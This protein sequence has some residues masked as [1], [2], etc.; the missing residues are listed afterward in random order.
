MVT[1]SFPSY[2]TSS[3]PFI[4]KWH[5]REGRV[6]D[7][8]RLPH[9]DHH[10]PSLL[11]HHSNKNSIDS[12]PLDDNNNNIHHP[13]VGVKMEG[14]AKRRDGEDLLLDNGDMVDTSN[15]QLDRGRIASSH[16]KS[17]PRRYPINRLNSGISFLSD[18]GNPSTDS[19]PEKKSRVGIIVG[20]GL[21]AGLVAALGAAGYLY[22]SK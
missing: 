2:S 1:F 18:E 17:S 11:E 4:H 10:F 13:L 7:N 15:S 6:Q 21:A 16:F 3:D 9:Q 22:W 19:S 14:I 20:S 8:V 5:P 12:E